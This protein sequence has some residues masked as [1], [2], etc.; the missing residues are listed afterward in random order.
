MVE[1][2]YREL[3]KNPHKIWGCYDMIVPAV[4]RRPQEKPLNRSAALFWDTNAYDGLSQ[5]ALANLV[6]AMTD[7]CTSMKD[8]QGC[9]EGREC[10]GGTIA[11]GK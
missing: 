4:E 2:A 9:W 1:E 11:D 10:S 7:R 8:L 3:K 6:S 5:D